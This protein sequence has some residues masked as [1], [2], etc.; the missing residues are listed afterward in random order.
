[1]ADFTQKME[2]AWVGEGR[3][4]AAEIEESDGSKASFDENVADGETNLEFGFSFN[5]VT[6]AV[7]MLF[8]LSDQDV[9]IKT[10]DSGAPDDTLSPIADLPLFWVRAGGSYYYACPVTADVAKIFITNASGST[11][12]VQIEVLYD[13]AV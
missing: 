3:R 8:V 9:T 4:I 1:M 11:A 5:V 7:M 13:A 12:R 6:N 10:N 2:V